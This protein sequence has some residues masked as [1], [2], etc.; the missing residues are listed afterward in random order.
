[1]N[2]LLLNAYYLGILVVFY[3][4]SGAWRK[5][6]LHLHTF[7]AML[8]GTAIFDNAIIGFG[9]VAYDESKITGIK[10]G[11]APIEDFAYAIAAVLL[12]T[13]VGALMRKKSS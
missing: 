7:A 2:Y 13:S 11:L 9:L 10:I 8:I 12:A 1:M 4:A 5:F 6:S 3:F